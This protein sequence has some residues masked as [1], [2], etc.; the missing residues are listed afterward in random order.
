MLF[1]SQ[2][3][4]LAFLPLVTALYYAVASSAAW[5][6]WVL[7][8]ASLVFYAWWDA[9][10]LIL[11][12]AQIT[13]TW[14]LALAHER[15][16][17]K[18]LLIAGIVLNLASLGTFKYLDFAL[19]SIEAATGLDLPRAHIVLPIGISF[20]SFQ[21]ISY[22]VDRMRGQAPIYAY[23]PFA[24]FVLLF[25]HLI[26]GPI[27]RHNE[28]VPQFDQD[29]RRQGLWMRIGIG[30]VIFTVGFGKKVLLADRFAPEVDR[31]FAKA[32]TATLSFGESWSA[33][34]GFSFQLFFDFSA[35]TEMA[36]GSAL[37]FGLLLPENFRRPYLATDLRDFWRRWHISLSTFLRDYLYIPLGGSRA[38][39]WRYVMATMV[40]MG[41]CGLWHGAGWT[42]VAWGLWHG[43]GLVSCHGWQQLGRPMPALLGWAI[44]MLFV[45]VGWVMFRATTF[46]S[47]T[48]IVM[49]MAGGN[50]LGG[51]L[52]QPRLM[53][54][55]A[56]AAAL[57]PSA[58]E[59]KDK[60]TVPHPAWA[61]GAA[62]VA[63]YCIL[64]VGRGA[65]VNF[66]YFQ[67]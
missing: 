34:L 57:I 64:E 66:I 8:A 10:F 27:V 51:A 13:L 20:F 47:A 24:L 5:R 41:L 35:Y 21:L 11:P 65:P 45:A 38:G 60:L 15:T 33:V 55:A 9:R 53:V 12:V 31:L 50:G 67:F 36:I 25:P 40:T 63:V 2:F 26:A 16:K 37:I 1:Q 59:I 52:A 22:L 6:Q 17:S 56:F 19:Q 48:S 4:V 23:R 62:A 58:Y 54:V 32:T 29:P 49:S 3:Y 39:P 30:L 44:T 43:V 28:L 7:I 14:L 18:A 42:F 46:D 61:A